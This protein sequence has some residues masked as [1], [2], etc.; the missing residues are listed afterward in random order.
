VLRRGLPGSEPCRRCPLR[1]AQA[2]D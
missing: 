2:P 1:R